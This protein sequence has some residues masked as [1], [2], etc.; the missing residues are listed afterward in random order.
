M[1]NIPIIHLGIIQFEIILPQRKWA[2]PRIAAVI[3]N[4]CR[5]VR[6]KI[7][8]ERSIALHVPLA[9]GQLKVGH[10]IL[11]RARLAS[12]RWPL[13]HS[14]GD[15]PEPRP[16]LRCLR[17]A[18]DTPY[19]F[20]ASFAKSHVEVVIIPLSAWPALAGFNESEFLGVVHPL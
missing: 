1:E 2:P 5:M 20:A 8:R 18:K 4:G 6:G 16:I 12:I 13:W 15:R 17:R 14:R 10:G 3:H 9:P 7:I 19:Y 11:A